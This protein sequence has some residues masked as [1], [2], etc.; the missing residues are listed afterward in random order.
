MRI[1]NLN[2]VYRSSKRYSLDHNT[3]HEHAIDQPRQQCMSSAW[4]LPSFIGPLNAY[5]CV[6][7]GVFTQYAMG[8]WAPTR[9]IWLFRAPIRRVCADT[10]IYFNNWI[11]QLSPKLRYSCINLNGYRTVESS[12]QNISYIHKSAVTIISNTTSFS[13]ASFFEKKTLF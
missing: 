13:H 8:G 7:Y 3:S 10:P 12:L 4:L 9:S 5:W 6:I 11:Y 1:S 2:T